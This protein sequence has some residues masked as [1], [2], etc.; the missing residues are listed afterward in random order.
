MANATFCLVPRGRRLASYRFLEAIQLGCIPV[1]LSNGHVLPFHE[2]IDWSACAVKADERLVLQV[3]EMLRQ[4]SRTRVDRMRSS[5]GALYRRFFSSVEKIVFLTFLQI[6]NRIAPQMALTRFV[7]QLHAPPKHELH[8]AGLQ[9]GLAPPKH[10]ARA[11]TGLTCVLHVTDASHV[12]ELE[13]VLLQMARNP[14]VRHVRLLWH[15][16]S[17]APT[18]GLTRFAKT[19]VEMFGSRFALDA[20]ETDAVLQ[21]APHATLSD[22]EV[23]SR[24]VT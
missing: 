10:V 23:S 20:I 19:R 22:L 3:P 7:N 6:E 15:L 17:S 11:A 13:R 8:V 24:R 12:R 18:R 9:L 14:L 16:N 4:M 5:C 2:L 21:M 1:L